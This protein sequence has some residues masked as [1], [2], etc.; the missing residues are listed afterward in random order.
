MNNFLKVFKIKSVHFVYTPTRWL[1][2]F[3]AALLWG[4][5]KIKCWLASLKT[6]TNFKNASSNPLQRACCGIQK[7]A[8]YS[9]TCSVTRMWYWKLFRKPPMTFIFRPTFPPVQWEVVT[10]RK[11]TND[12][13]SKPENNSVAAFSTSFSIRKCFHRSKKN[14][15]N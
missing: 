9:K 4:K 14:L 2:Y 15:F 12:R 6:L 8:C 10:W 1:S 3:T 11:P 7:L 13:N 5:W